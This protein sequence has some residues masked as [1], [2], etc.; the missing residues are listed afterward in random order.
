V[1]YQVTHATEYYYGRPVPLSHNIVHLRPRQTTLQSVLSYALELTPNPIDRAE[2]IDFFGNT[3]SCFSIHEAHDRL[4]LVARSIVDVMTFEPPPASELPAWEEAARLLKQQLDPDVLDARQF[5]YESPFI[6]TSSELANYA[7]PSFSP[8]RPM[9]ECVNELTQ[10]ICDD[11]TFDTDYTTV[12]TPVLEVLHHR[13]GVC[14]D[15]AHLEI[16]CL[17]SLGLAARYVSGYLVTEP[18]PGQ[19]RLIGADASHA[20]ISVFFPGFGWIDFDP[21]NGVIPSSGHISLAWARDYGDVSPVRGVVLG[22]YRHSL[23]V[24]VDVAQIV[25]EERREGTVNA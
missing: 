1:K 14:Q 25:A 19:P 12:G 13:H 3:V 6:S 23:R 20:W 24:S 16:G 7:Q 8:G 10:R 11:F 5:I 2:R 21:T 9:L 17:R 4:R 22:G 15:F 18:P